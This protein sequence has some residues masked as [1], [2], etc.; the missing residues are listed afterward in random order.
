ME[1]LWNY[2]LNVENK[3]KELCV[4]LE[5][6]M[7]LKKYITKYKDYETKELAR[8][9]A[10]RKK[11]VPYASLKNK[12]IPVTRPKRT[13]SKETYTKAIGNPYG[14][15]FPKAKRLIKKVSK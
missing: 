14:T 13:F 7:G 11:I 6:K 12:R 4:N 3:Q 10:K 9:A 2:V 1:H 5:N 15:R 8:R